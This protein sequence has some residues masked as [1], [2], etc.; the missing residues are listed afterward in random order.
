LLNV[1]VFPAVL[2]MCCQVLVCCDVSFP[3]IKKTGALIDYI[4]SAGVD[5]VMEL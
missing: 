2:E 5:V 3:G 4:G 1:G